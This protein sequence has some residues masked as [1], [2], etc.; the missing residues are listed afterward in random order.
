MEVTK[1][2]SNGG[3]EGGRRVAEIKMRKRGKLVEVTL[4]VTTKGS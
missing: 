3:W 4:L 1:E 2:Y